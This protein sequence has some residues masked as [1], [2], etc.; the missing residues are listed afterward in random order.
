MWSVWLP[1]CLKPKTSER[2]EVLKYLQLAVTSEKV[3]PTPHPTYEHRDRDF[4]VNS[5][6]PSSHLQ[7]WLLSWR[8]S[9]A[10][11]LLGLGLQ[12]IVPDKGCLAGPHH[13][14][15]PHQIGATQGWGK[16]PSGHLIFWSFWLREPISPATCLLRTRRVRLWG[17]SLPWWFKIAARDLRRWR[18]QV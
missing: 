10:T 12:L 17:N 1:L 13:K 3:V 14:M 16:T 9:K 6:E 8:K 5:F 18:C 7:H 2:K 11:L 4:P 15:N